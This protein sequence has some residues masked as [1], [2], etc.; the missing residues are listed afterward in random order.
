MR[1]ATH[2]NFPND[3]VP[4]ASQISCRFFSAKLGR[5]GGRESVESAILDMVEERKE[6][7]ANSLSL[8]GG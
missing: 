1:V 5:R 6:S 2:R 4:N 3:L 7:G 8:S